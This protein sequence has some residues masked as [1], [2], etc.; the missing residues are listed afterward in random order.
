M[1]TKG[2]RLAHNQAISTGREYPVRFCGTPVPQDRHPDIV[3]SDI[4]RGLAG[5]V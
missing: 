3:V 1:R 4:L 2:E 5:E